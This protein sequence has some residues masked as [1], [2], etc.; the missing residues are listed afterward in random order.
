M[1]W[2]EVVPDRVE[3]CYIVTKKIVVETIE[4]DSDV[5]LHGSYI[6]I[7]YE[8]DE[9]KCIFFKFGKAV[10]PKTK[11]IKWSIPRLVAD[12]HLTAEEAQR[13]FGL[14]LIPGSVLGG[15]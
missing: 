7:N 6:K 14:N 4:R 9:C 3:T 13:Y 12:R 8:K 5:I 15:R 1:H 10:R 11:H 2:R